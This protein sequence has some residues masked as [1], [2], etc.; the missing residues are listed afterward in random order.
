MADISMAVEAQYELE[1]RLETLEVRF[2]VILE[3]L[4][5]EKQKSLQNNNEDEC[6]FKSVNSKLSKIS[7]FYGKYEKWS[8]F[9]NQ[10]M[11]LITNNDDLSDGEK[12][13][14][15]HST[16]NGEVKQV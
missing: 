2:K 3:D 16:L 14:Y 15:L 11:N 10:F 5:S 12:F 1:D 4:T 13:Y 9:E 8:R 7:M 6:Y